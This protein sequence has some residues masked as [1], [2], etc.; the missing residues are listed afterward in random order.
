MFV[1]KYS[2]FL[3]YTNIERK[4]VCHI[5]V[6]QIVLLTLQT[7]MRVLYFQNAISKV[8]C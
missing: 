6:S 2:F 7:I 8:K 3:M 1:Q 5:F 4:N